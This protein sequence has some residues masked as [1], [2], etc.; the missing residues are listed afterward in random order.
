MYAV[1]ETGGKQYRVEEGDVIEVERLDGTEHALRPVLLVDGDDVRSTPAELEGASVDVKV[2]D[3]VKGPK[4]RGMTYKAST[5][6]RR[7]WGHRQ[8]YSRVEIV[9]IGAG[10]ARK[11]QPSGEE[12]AA[13]APSE[14]S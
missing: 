8:R 7:R 1:I 14:E 13:A 6:N 11:Q 12:S 2:L 10:G 4:I 5:R 9:G 3:E